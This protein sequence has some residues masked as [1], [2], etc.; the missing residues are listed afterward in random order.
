MQNEQIDKPEIFAS[1]TDPK[2]QS[3]GF[4]KTYFEYAMSGKQLREQLS[5]GILNK[6]AVKL[7]RVFY[8]AFVTCVVDSMTCF[9]NQGF[10]QTFR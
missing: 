10:E 2:H 1:N 4:A 3:N 5:R 9:H 6:M 8:A 7:K